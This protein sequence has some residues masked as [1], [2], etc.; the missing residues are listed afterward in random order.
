M[1]LREEEERVWGEVERLRCVWESVFV[2]RVG[3][4]EGRGKEF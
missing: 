1:S 2:V 4:C 3:E